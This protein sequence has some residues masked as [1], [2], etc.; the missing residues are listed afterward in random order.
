MPSLS[1]NVGLNNGRKL[2]FTG[3]A[4]P[5]FPDVAGTSS[6]L[7]DS[8]GPYTKTTAVPYGFDFTGSGNIYYLY[9]TSDEFTYYYWVMF[10]GSTQLATSISSPAINLLANKW[11]KINGFFNGD[12][13]YFLGLDSTNTTTSQTA[14]TIPL[15][16]W[17][18]AITITAA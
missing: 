5:A 8:F 15:S 18:P 12:E 4:A 16:N 1:L 2:P 13:S 9:V 3:G 14:A 7:V 10:S 17:S 11:Y 6:I